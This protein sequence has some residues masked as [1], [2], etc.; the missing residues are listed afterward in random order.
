M[1]DEAI[2]NED[3]PTVIDLAVNDTD[4]EGSLDKAT[5]TILPTDS[6]KNGSVKVN[7]DGT[8]LYTPDAQY[9]GNDTFI[10]SIYDT[11][12]AQSNLATVFISVTEINDFPIAK[13]DTATTP[14][15]DAITIDVSLN[16]TDVDGTVDPSTIVITV[17][18]NN[19]TATVEVDGKV[20]YS[21]RGNFNGVDTFIYTIK[22]DRGATSNPATV[23]V[24]V[25]DGNDA[26]VIVDEF[27]QPTDTIS[28]VLL[29]DGSTIIKINAT[30]IEGDTLD[31]IQIIEG[32]SNG[33]ISGLNDGDTTITYV[34]DPNFNGTNEFKAIVCDNGEPNECDTVTILLTIQSVNDNPV[35]SESG[36]SVDTLRTNVEED[37]VIEICLEATDVDGNPVDV[38]SATSAQAKGELEIFPA[39][40]TCFTYTP[41]ENEVGNDTIQ[42]VVCDDQNPKGCDT[43]QYIIT[44]DPVNDAPVANSEAFTLDPQDSVVI[45]VQRNDFDV[46]GD[47]LTTS[48]IS[49]PNNGNAFVV[50]GDS[51]SFIRNQPQ[52]ENDTI[53]YSICDPSGLCDTAELVLLFPASCWPP[54][55][56]DETGT[57]KED[58]SKLFDVLLNDFDPNEDPITLSQAAANGIRGIAVIENG[59][60]RYTPNPDFFGID[61]IYYSVCDTTTAGNDLCP[62]ENG[63]PLCDTAL[64]IVTV[65]N[66]N[67]APVI[68]DGEPITKTIDEDGN[69]DIT[70]SA[71]DKDGDSL[72]VV[73]ILNGPSNG[74]VTGL[75]DGDTTFNYTPDANFNGLD[76]FQA[77]VC[78]N[79]TPTRC[80]TIWI[81]IDVTPI[82][83]APSFNEGD[84][85]NRTIDEDTPLEF[86]LNI[87]DVDGPNLE[88]VVTKNPENGTLSFESSGDTCLTYTPDPNFSGSDTVRILVCDNGTPNL[89]DDVIIVFT[90]NEVED[91][92]VAL[93]DSVELD[94]DGQITFGPL[95][96]DSD[97]DGDELTLSEIVIAPNNGTATIVDDSIQFT[98]NPNFFGEDSLQYAVCDP[99]GSCDTAWVYFTVNSVNDS[100]VAVDD[101]AFTNEDESVEIELLLNDN[102]IDDGLD[103]AGIVITTD[104]KNGSVSIDT[105]TGIV[106][107][108]PNANT[109]G[110]DTFTYTVNDKSGVASNVATVIVDVGGENDPPTANNDSFD[111][112][113]ETQLSG[114]VLF[115]DSDPEN[116]LDSTSITINS[117]DSTKHGTLT[118]SDDG[119]FTYEPIENFFGVDSFIYSVF[120]NDGLQSNLATVILNIENVNDAPIA[121]RD[122]IVVDEDN[123]VFFFA[124]GND[125]DVDSEID[126][127]S[128]QVLESTKNG[129]LSFNFATGES[130]YVPNPNFHGVDTFIY[131][132]RDKQGRVSN[133]ATSIITV[134]EVNDSPV[135]VNDNASTNEDNTVVIPILANDKDID[136]TLNKKGVTIVDSTNNGSIVINDNGT[137]TYLPNADYNGADTFTYTVTDD[138]GA[139]SNVATVF[140]NVQPIN[141]KPIAENNGVPASKFFESLD[142]DESI[143][144]KVDG[145]DI[146][147]HDFDVTA[148]TD[149]PNNGFITGLSNGDTAFTYTP[150]PNFNGND[151]VKLLLC[152]DGTPVACDTLTYIFT[153]NP[154]ND[155]PV[156][157]ENGVPTDTITTELDEDGEISICIEMSDVDGDLLDVKSATANNGAID[158]SPAGDSCFFYTPDENFF[159]NDTIQVIACDDADPQGCDTVY[160]VVT[161]NGVNDAPVANNDGLTIDP[162]DSVVIKV[163][164]NDTDVDDSILITTIISGPND[165]RVG[166]IN[167][168]SIWF[169]RDSLRFEDDTLFYSICD[170]EGLCDTARVILLFPENC[171][172]PIAS[173]DYVSTNEESSKVI[174]AKSNDFDPN[175]D[176]L[177]ISQIVTQPNNGTASIISGKVKYSPNVNFSGF[178]TVYY[179]VCDTSTANN[180]K[181]PGVYN[182]PL[183]D[184][185]M[186]V[187]EVIN[188]ND[189]PV[190]TDGNGN[191]ISRIDTTINEDEPIVISLPVSDVEGDSVD[192]IVVRKGPFNGTVTGLAD[193]DTSFTYTPN[194]NFFGTDSFNVIVCDDGNRVKCDTIKVVINVAPVNDAPIILND[195]GESAEEESVFMEEDGILQIC[196]PAKDVDGPDLGVGGIV[197]QPTN[198]VLS[199]ISSTDTCLI[200]TPEANY[201]GID[202]VTIRICDNGI[203]NLCDT[204]TYYINIFRKDDRPVAINDSVTILEDDTAFINV[205]GN[206]YDD[207]NDPI[208]VSGITMY[209][210][211]G[212]I[213]ITNDDSLT[214]IPNPGYFGED[215][216]DYVLCD[217]TGSCD[218]A[219]VYINVEFVNDNPIAQND[220]VYG[221]EDEV[222]VIDVQA[223]DTDEENTSVVTAIVV[224]PQNGSVSIIN[225]DSVR[226]TPNPNFHGVDSFQY[227]I[228]EPTGEC[229]TAWVFI[230]LTPVND[231]PIAV[232]DTV[233]TPEDTPI[234]IDVQ[235]NDTD[236]DGGL[237]T[238]ITRILISTVNGTA[239][240]LNG[241]KVEYTPNPNFTGVDSFQYVVC[242]TSNTCDTAWVFIT[243]SGEN[244]KPVAVD[245]EVT[246]NEE[247]SITVDVQA[248]DSD[249][250]GGVLTTSIIGGPSN[251]AGVV[252]NGDSITYTPNPNFFGDDTI[253]YRICDDGGSCDTAILIIHVL[254]IND[255]PIAVNDTVESINWEQIDIIIS[256]NDTFVDDTSLVFTVIDGPF[257]GSISQNGDTITYIPSMGDCRP[258]SF[259][260]S[261]CDPSNACDTAWVFIEINVPDSDGD[262]LPDMV[263]SNTNDG[264]N[265]G[266]PDYLDVDSDNDGISDRD[267]SLGYDACID[268]FGGIPDSDGDGIPDYIDTDSDNDGIPD[269]EEGQEDCDN[270]GIPNYRDPDVCPD[271]N[272]PSNTIASPNGFSPNGDGVNDTWV[273]KNLEL[274]PDNELI[275]FNRWG[276]EVFSV[277]GYRND[278]SGDSNSKFTIGNGLPVGTYFYVLKIRYKGQVYEEADYIYLSR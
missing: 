54:I 96:N 235:N 102:D 85:M 239:I 172:P 193:G 3:V 187:I 146:E 66:Q 201:N 103:S 67:D 122:E 49:G 165:G 252:I 15:N 53:V 32:P 43:V 93:N 199:E 212:I 120:D 255:P 127:T 110:L 247:V 23:I 276:N 162:R 37:G 178:D 73:N 250:E 253:T 258:D 254:P 270:D 4:V 245:D 51:I 215:S 63:G 220:S 29:E 104:P 226:Y 26:P 39:G 17:N 257:I 210:T 185:A 202:T 114:N 176:T 205:T 262:G 57:M 142:E 156:I 271:L 241:D 219:R 234:I 64:L 121:I 22:D 5:I 70:I 216:V 147:G 189:A 80:D 163:Q 150:N 274:Y 238:M 115:N 256:S 222:F 157:S 113:E 118:I 92:P 72:D 56:A 41:N 207:D 134:N 154:V 90:V 242:D 192:V 59:K 16:D 218:T 141:D 48:I 265:D 159:G 275:I 69:I 137:V 130:K 30:D 24:T 74:N 182:G 12:S 116:G 91:A 211:N 50:N 106:T 278:W 248:N 200:Y 79:G 268:L 203:P 264:D 149:E 161:V 101:V 2:I 227:S 267:E 233:T 135:A 155:V 190:I 68:S 139:I 58:Q 38:F 88:S 99:K 86:C 65:T 132:V 45:K 46:D 117:G 263:E 75:S 164:R 31:V 246:T 181:C 111:G 97:G 168:D 25:G 184:T 237:D 196:I 223:N 183:C 89:C 125:I 251:G 62:G 144:I 105:T 124:A 249:P 186:I 108:T 100:P 1:N 136:G 19:G 82:N 236:V 61:S 232:N 177:I 126:S 129:K 198:G 133:I 55:A 206:D 179:Q 119:T 180:P 209:P 173:D 95:G 109:F 143:T 174:N 20:T 52:F 84:T 277:K 44:I 213:L 231:A 76:S 166:V 228:C 60:I 107:Y 260:Y 47:D 188:I 14:E 11:D 131:V 261:V 8:V 77:V 71:D 243:V 13:N 128:V 266:L 98:P 240:V 204:I 259:Q 152:D 7:N 138:D 214:Y 145:S 244:D 269:S 175:G 148:V 36:I 33:S 167:N 6:A 169:I 81:V 153:V 28:I 230:T 78:D 194:P 272:N 87:K 151:T 34:P 217:S 9:F 42:V 27:D 171:W 224:G 158:L 170:D 40:D 10:Y 83:D 21:P 160:V 94:E 225:G 195:D 221:L 197:L 123:V 18:P 229:A 273:I 35:I 191:P 208:K 140:I 112:V